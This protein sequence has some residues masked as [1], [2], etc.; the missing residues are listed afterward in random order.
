M[1]KPTP[2]HVVSVRIPDELLA[3]IKA[4]ASSAGM[5]FTIFI[6]VAAKHEAERLLKRRAV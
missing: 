3:S 1:P 5:P 6:R 2:L 4:A